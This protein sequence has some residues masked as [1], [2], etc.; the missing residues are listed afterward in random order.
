M[1]GI[2]LRFTKNTMDAEDLLHDGF[3]KVLTNLSN[4]KHEGSF[5]G[6]MRRLMVNTA[7][8]HYRRK[9]SHSEQDFETSG[10]EYTEFDNSD[11]LK[12]LAADELLKLVQALPDGYRMVF[13]LYVI[14]GYKHQ[15]IAQMLG[16]TENTSKS[17]LAKA[18]RHLQDAVKKLNYEPAI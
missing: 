1:Y 16:V 4:F 5:E 7:I 3:I 18:R 8:N 13:N 14:E 17:Q 15:E 6:W 2:C 9:S 12:T 10:V 11:V